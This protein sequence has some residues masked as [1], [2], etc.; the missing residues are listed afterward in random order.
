MEDSKKGRRN[1]EKGQETPSPHEDRE[2][3]KE[4]IVY[5][6]REGERKEKRIFQKRALGHVRGYFLC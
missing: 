4:S 5:K 1:G 6:M 3:G 2:K